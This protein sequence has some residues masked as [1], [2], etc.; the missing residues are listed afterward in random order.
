MLLASL[1]VMTISLSRKI[2]CSLFKLTVLVTLVLTCDHKPSAL[3]A[4]PSLAPFPCKVVKERRLH[5]VRWDKG[6]P[7][8]Y[9]RMSGELLSVIPTPN[10]DASS[11]KIERSASINLMYGNIVNALSKAKRLTIPRVP[12]NALKPFW[13]EHLDELTCDSIFGTIYG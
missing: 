10:I 11:S 13:S 7:T 2:Y 4:N 8:N 9:Y 3:R 12:C 6:S 5:K 1:P